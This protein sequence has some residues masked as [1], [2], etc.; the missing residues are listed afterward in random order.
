ML[1]YKNQWG[2]TYSNSEITKLG[3]YENTPQ[4]SL[5]LILSCNLNRD[6][7]IL[8]VGSGTTSLI[9][10]LLQ[11]DYSNIIVTDISKVALDHAK[12]YLDPKESEKVKWIVDDVV[13]PKI[14]TR[15]TSIDLWH[16]RTILHLLLDDEQQQAYLKTL[17]MLVSKGGYV[18][19]A[20]FSLEGAKKFNGL[21]VK[22]YD[23]SMIEEFL[24]REFRLLKHFNYS[25][26][27][28][29]GDLRPY[30]YTLFQRL[31]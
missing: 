22:N 8:D 17:R 7:A 19:I 23:S 20:A 13:D 26:K 4:P 15:L 11:D 10:Y 14:I 1:D 12:K 3:W 24:G 5:D 30:V 27:I 16:D 2:D 31:T 25:F 9:K 18:I 21:E 28:P 29:S 6:A